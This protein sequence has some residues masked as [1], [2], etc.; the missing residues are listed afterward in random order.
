MHALFVEKY[1]SDICKKMTEN[2][3]KPEKFYCP[4]RYKFYY[5]YFKQH[6]NYG[7]GQSRTDVCGTCEELKV[8]F[9]S[10]KNRDIS[11]RLES[12]YYCIRKKLS[13]F[14]IS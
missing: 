2:N 1:F 6:F 3:V 13:V 5:D 7:F 8:K 4:V 9:A 12:H 10:Q 14:T 11:K